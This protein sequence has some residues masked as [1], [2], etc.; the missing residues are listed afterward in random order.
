MLQFK[1]YRSRLSTGRSSPDLRRKSRSSIVLVEAVA[2]RLEKDGE[3]VQ[4]GNRT[5]RVL[6]A[7]PPAPSLYAN[8]PPAACATLSRARPVTGPG[9][10]ARVV[11]DATAGRKEA[12]QPLPPTGRAVLDVAATVV[13]LADGDTAVGTGTG[14]RQSGRPWS[15]P[16]RPLGLEAEVRLPGHAHRP[17][18]RGPASKIRHA[19]R[20][21]P[22]AVAARLNWAKPDALLLLRAGQASRRPRSL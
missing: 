14:T 5:R 20:S 16:T 12:D 17:L 6:W 10:R 13:D 11:V 4:V 22:S 1:R 7:G 3:T 21:W 15:R 8:R 9:L 2:A 18:G 19:R